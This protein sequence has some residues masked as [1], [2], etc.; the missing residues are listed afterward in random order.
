MNNSILAL[1]NTS[2]VS[3]T[4]QG[5]QQNKN[6]VK[7]LSILLANGWCLNILVESSKKNRI[8]TIDDNTNGILWSTA[9][10]GILANELSNKRPTKAGD[11]F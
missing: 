2:K 4:P 1:I 6:I 10:T 7:L 5:S 8:F 9:C 3:T 11:I